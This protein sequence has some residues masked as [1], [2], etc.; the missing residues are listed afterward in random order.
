MK[1]SKSLETGIPD[2]VFIEESKSLETGIPDRD[3]CEKFKV[4]GD[5]DSRQGFY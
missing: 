5:G 4:P 2:R 3:F 1:N